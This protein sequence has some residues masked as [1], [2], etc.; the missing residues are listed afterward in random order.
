[1]AVDVPVTE[2]RA[3]DGLSEF[4]SVDGV[5]NIVDPSAIFLIDP[6]TVF[7]VDTGV[8]QTKIPPTLW[9]EDDSI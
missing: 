2:W 1:M 4:S 7:I 6:S 8:I 9:E 3:T 5:F